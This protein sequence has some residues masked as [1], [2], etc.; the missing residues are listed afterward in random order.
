MNIEGV[1]LESRPCPMGC[2][3]DDELVLEGRDRLLGLPGE[4]QVV[5]CRVC[6][7]MRTDPRPTPETMAFYYPDEYG[8]Y[9]NTRVEANSEES[10]LQ[11]RIK[12][13]LKRLIKL[14]I[15]SVPVLPP[16]RMLEVG[17]A[18]GAFLHRMANLGW[19]VE[20]IEFS[21]SAAEA[22]RSL[23]YSVHA[24]TLETAPPRAQ[25]YNLIVGWMVLE[26]LHEPIPA[27]RKLHSWAR[28]GAGLAISVPNAAAWEFA[29]F[30][31]AWFALQLPNHLYHPTAETLV[32][33]LERGGWR[34]ER[35]LHQRDVGNLVASVGYFLQDRQLLPAVASRLIAF[36]NQKKGLL[37]FFL[38]PLAY[39]LSAIGQTG[40][41]T[42]WALRQDA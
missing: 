33:L 31:N 26:H 27:L 17:C 25:A 28:P 3:Q 12:G 41:M 5:R 11:Q 9:H 10:G 21:P 39:F 8:P 42:V 35:V 37:Y 36:P 13:L 40:R 1:E 23:G 24:G 30:K 22:A 19:E 32:K 18:S 29:F 15:D 20:G 2:S 14:H 4:F 34:I 16:G 38:L 7:L 6:G